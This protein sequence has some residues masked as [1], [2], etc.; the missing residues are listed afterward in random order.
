MTVERIDGPREVFGNPLKHAAHR[1]D[2]IRLEKLLSLGGI[3]L[4]A[5]VFVH[6]SFDPL[7]GRRMVLGE[8][9]V[10]GK[11][12]GL[13]NAVILAEAQAPFLSRW[14][15]EYRSFRSGGHDNYWDEHSVAIPYQLSKKYPDEVT[16]L[17]HYTFFWPTFTEH[18]IAR[19]FD[20]AEP[21][22]TSLAYANHLWESPAWDRYLK[23]LTPKRVRNVYSNF[24]EW[25][26]PMVE[27]LPDD[28]GAPGTVIR[29][30]HGAQQTARRVRTV[31]RKKVL[32]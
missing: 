29:I 20:S 32:R 4:D 1:A 13:C 10:D 5:D 8:E 16:V 3:Y 28:F 31:L 25:A 2:V 24:H 27:A 11:A 26:R 18:G 21:I 14:Y 6:R 19:I 15:S 12:V 23:H 17:P 22:D 7:L 30:A 9:L